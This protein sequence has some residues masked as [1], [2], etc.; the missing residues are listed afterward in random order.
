MS[1]KLVSDMVFSQLKALPRKAAERA[2][3]DLWQ[4]ISTLL[5]AFPPEERKNYFRHAGYA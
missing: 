5:D 2:V 4:R 3:D 1:L